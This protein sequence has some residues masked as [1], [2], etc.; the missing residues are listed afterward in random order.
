[1]LSRL[2]SRSGPLW[3]QQQRILT[4]V[5]FCPLLLSPGDGGEGVEV[6]ASLLLACSPLLRR[7]LASTCCGA[8]SCA[9]AAVVL[10]STTSAA[11]NQLVQVLALG[12]V[13]SFSCTNFVVGQNSLN[14]SVFLVFIIDQEWNSDFGLDKDRKKD[15]WQG[16]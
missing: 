10:P 15:S 16:F 13:N 7:T 2:S 3:L 12:S 1:M 8:C 9:P 5:T 11:L 4:N 6:E 14:V